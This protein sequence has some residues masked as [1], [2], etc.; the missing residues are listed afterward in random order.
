LKPIIKEVI[1]E[2]E[3]IKKVPLQKF[4]E[5]NLK[6][7]SKVQI[8]SFIN[9]SSKNK[10][11]KISSESINFISI[12]KPKI[13][14]QKPKFNEL[15]MNSSIKLN[16][17]GIAPSLLMS[18]TKF[19][20]NTMHKFASVQ[21]EMTYKNLNSIETLNKACSSQLLN[22]QKEKEKMQKI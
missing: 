14:E 9:I 20:K 16:F 8:I 22:T 17:K 15:K 13:I 3:V 7:S 11:L 12:P 19:K 5:K 21:T 18:P 4:E 6:I 10:K 2:V 1:K